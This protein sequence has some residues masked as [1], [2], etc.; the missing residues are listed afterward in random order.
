MALYEVYELA[1]QLREP[2]QN[3]PLF[4]ALSPAFLAA[5]LAAQWTIS[6]LTSRVLRSRSGNGIWRGQD[7]CASILAFPLQD[8]MCT[9]VHG[10]EERL[11]GETLQVQL[12]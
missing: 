11:S 2:A 9:I 3:V 12:I 7:W 5:F 4:R 1:S 6:Y 10:K 8:P